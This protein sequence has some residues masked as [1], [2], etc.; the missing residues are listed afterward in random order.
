MAIPT[1]PPGT[2]ARR[3]V[4]VVACTAGAAIIGVV[5]LVYALYVIPNQMAGLPSAPM[6]LFVFVAAVG[7]LSVASATGYWIE[8]TWGWFVHLVSVLGQLVFPGSLFEF[9]LDLYHMVGWIAP[10]IS[11]AILILM[12]LRMRRTRDSRQ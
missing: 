1:V 5:I 10:L 11:L 9:K 8:R 4:L 2:A 12:G 6:E 3:S 7:L